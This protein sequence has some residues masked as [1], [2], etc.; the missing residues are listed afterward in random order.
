L[1][2]VH[3]CDQGAVEEMT[4]NAGMHVWIADSLKVLKIN[5]SLLPRITQR[6]HT[7]CQYFSTENFSTEKVTADTASEPLADR[8]ATSKGRRD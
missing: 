4:T 7:I 6:P 2:I 1:E 8:Q 3:V 5:G